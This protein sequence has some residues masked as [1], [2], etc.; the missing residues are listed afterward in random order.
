MYIATPSKNILRKNEKKVAALETLN[1][2]VNVSCPS[3][4]DDVFPSPL[5]GLQSGSSLRPQVSAR[6]LK[7]TVNIVR[8]V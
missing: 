1:S 7:R 2:R 5:A 6:V 8:D 3:H 4:C